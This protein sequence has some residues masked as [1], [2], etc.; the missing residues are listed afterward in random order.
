MSGDFVWKVNVRIKGQRWTVKS[1]NMPSR[2]L[3][4]V[5]RLCTDC[6]LQH[7]CREVDFA[8]G[9]WVTARSARGCVHMHALDTLE[10]M[11]KVRVG[12]DELQRLP[13]HWALGGCP[14]DT[15]V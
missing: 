13:P 2:V 6:H 12:R 5:R 9:Y 15:S 10:I 11:F 1:S 3:L 8:H 7:S 4:V 14:I